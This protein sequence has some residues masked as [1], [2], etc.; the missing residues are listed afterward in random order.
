[1]DRNLGEKIM[2]ETL[3]IILLFYTYHQLTVSLTFCLLT[4]VFL[5]KVIRN[6]E[7]WLPKSKI[8]RALTFFTMISGLSIIFA[9]VKEDA[10]HG[11]LE[12]LIPYMI[13]V[14]LLQQVDKNKYET[15]ERK[16][17]EIGWGL[18]LFGIMG[19]FFD[20][21]ITMSLI[22]QN[23]LISGIP[24]PNT[25]AVF[26]LVCIILVHKLDKTN[27]DKVFIQGVLW[28]G[29]VLTGS[30]AIMILSVVVLSL[31]IFREKDWSRLISTIMGG[32]VGIFLSNAPQFTPAQERVSSISPYATEW[33]E[34]LYY[35]KDAFEL[36]KLHPFGVGAKNG[37]LYQGRIQSAYYYDIP[38]VHN[39]LLQFAV[40]F[41]I[42]VA[43]L[44]LTVFLVYMC[45]TRDSFHNK[46]AVLCL[47]V[48][49]I[50]DF[51]W[52]YPIILSIFYFMY[53]RAERERVAVVMLNK[54]TKSVMTVVLVCA[55]ALGLYFVEFSYHY[56][57]LEPEKA[58][59]IYLQSSKARVMLAESYEEKGLYNEAVRELE[60][61]N[62]IVEGN[63]EKI[64][65]KLIT[66]YLRKEELEKA[67]NASIRLVELRPFDIENFELKSSIGIDLAEHEFEN[68]NFEKAKAA[69]EEVLNIERELEMYRTRISP[70]ANKLKHKV[71]LVMTDELLDNKKEAEYLLSLI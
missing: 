18:C 25:F 38:Y 40:D 52:K 2:L 34:R 67:F 54:M 71:Y 46:L 6:G 31:L 14:L 33:L 61:A 66:N 11:Y 42:I 29:I 39:G 68:K 60:Y 44:F 1:M 8:G 28:C 51:D 58:L 45:K 43:V 17:L 53:A 63:N 23:R 56:T 50:I 69:L 59:G 57:N 26:L 21:H 27:K 70:S 37:I 41:G 24:Y 55:L 32:V 62:D 15:I 22:S 5:I 10:I 3:F 30:R 7:L 16:T 49:G 19:S 4:L 12:I 9:K 20:E 36:I 65:E 13:F 48:H 35:Y 47:F 64:Y